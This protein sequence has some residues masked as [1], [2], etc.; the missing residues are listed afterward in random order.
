MHFNLLSLSMTIILSFK[1]LA[2]WNTILLCLLVHDFF[3]YMRMKKEQLKQALYSFLYKTSNIFHIWLANNELFFNS[4]ASF[5]VQSNKIQ[6][7]EWYKICGPA[8]KWSIKC[9]KSNNGTIP[10]RPQSYLDW[11]N[12]QSCFADDVNFPLNTSNNDAPPK[13][14]DYYLTWLHLCETVTAKNWPPSMGLETL[15]Y[16]ATSL[17]MGSDTINAS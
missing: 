2:P 15:R 7:G 4:L 14:L 5:W 11:N 16:Y 3:R 1:N 13:E 10:Q 12:F 6:N 17:V 8:V 9:N